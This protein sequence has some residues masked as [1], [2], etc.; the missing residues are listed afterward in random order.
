MNLTAMRLLVLSGGILALIYVVY[1]IFSILKEDQGS[2]KM[3]EISRH[4]RLGSFAFLK[5]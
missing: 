3:Q 4:I 2:R 5:R 1:L